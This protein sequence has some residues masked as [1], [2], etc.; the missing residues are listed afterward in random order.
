MQPLW[1]PNFLVA[2]AANFLMS[3]SFYL[4]MPTL[5]LYLAGELGIAKG[6]V[7]A[8]MCAYVIAALFMRPFS[9]FLI[10]SFPR[11]KLYVCAYVAFAGV[12]LGYPFA[13]GVAGFL[14]LRILH[15]LVWGVISTAG[16]TI[17][18]DIVPS[19]RRGE[20]I[21]YFGVSTNVAMALGPM[22]G[23]LLSRYDF[24]WVFRASIGAA[25]VGLVLSLLIQVPARA[26]QPHRV[27]SWDRFLLLRGV[28]SGVALLFVTMSYGMILAYVA[29]Y[30]QENHIPQAGA[31]FIAMALSIILARLL[32]GKMLDQGL[33]L[34]VAWVGAA[35][36]CLGLLVLG[37]CPLAPCYFGMA[38]LL[39]L[40]YGMVFPA[41]QNHMVGLASHHERGTANS[42][43]FTAFD[44]GAGGGMLMGGL[45]AQGLGLWLGF[46][47]GAG[48]A[49][50]SSLLLVAW[51]GKERAAQ[52]QA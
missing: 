14:V 12:A 46:V 41:V 31:F 32:T 24:A 4:L 9:G 7:G 50:L 43:F 33:G 34:R 28:P 2:F 29:M 13:S 20:G 44:L 5:P 1:T 36:C 42:T 23:L 6:V 39:G 27:L 15:G 26:P 49:L 19:S 51:V 11:K 18:I 48:G 3:F 45:V 16:N 10:D 40:A 22:T 47:L 25:L 8:I 21:G 38:L 52:V 35:L 30:G 17:G 37:L